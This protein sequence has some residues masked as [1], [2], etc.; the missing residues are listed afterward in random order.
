M[1]QVVFVGSL[2][3]LLGTFSG[4]SGTL[5]PEGQTGAICSPTNACNEGLECDQGL[6]GPAT[7]PGTTDP[8]WQLADVE[9]TEKDAGNE[10]VDPNGSTGLEDGD[11]G[12]GGLDDVATDTTGPTGLGDFGAPCD[13][14]LDCASGLCA[15]HMGDTVCTKTCESEC[16]AGWSCE[17]V[18]L[19]GGDPIYL[20]VSLFE[21]LCQPC[22][23]ASDCE[24]LTSIAACVGYGAEG[25]FCGAACDVDGDCPEAFVCQEAV[26]TRGGGSKQCVH[27]SGV[28]SCSE[29]AISLGLQ[30]E[31]EI[32]NDYGTC[33]AARSCTEDGLTACDALTPAPEACNGIDDDCNGELDEGALCDDGDPCTEDLCEGSGGCQNVIA[34]SAPC[35]DG[36]PA[37]SGDLCN[38]LGECGG[39]AIDCPLGLCELESTPNGDSCDVTFKAD[40]AVC[41]D[42]DVDT[43]GDQCDGSGGCAGS[44]YAC[45]ATQCEATS[46]TNGEG[47]EVEHWALGHPC[48][49]GNTATTGDQCD[50]QGL[51]AGTLYECVPNQCENSSEADGEGCVATYK[52]EGIACDDG[53]LSTNG[54][55]CDGQGGCA[56]NPYT[57][58]VT[59]CDAVSVPNGVAATPIIGPKGWLA[60]TDWTRLRMISVTVRGAAQAHLTPALLASVSSAPPPTVRDATSSMPSRVRRAMTVRMARSV[61]NATVKGAAPGLRMPARLRSARSPLYLTGK[62]VCLLLRRRA[63]SVMTTTPGPKM[64][65]AMRRAAVSARPLGVLPRFV[66]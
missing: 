43:K 61:T 62:V 29:Q 40:G 8:D 50:G 10:W 22:V 13:E 65:P 24:S 54:D 39:V 57:C 59:Q 44:P 42:D 46:V 25:A 32:T 38:E 35:D 63:P 2:A 37:T 5:T 34:P 48:D 20:C 12:A 53:D 45:T 6:C 58:P 51:C 17:Q 9:D 28:C 47:C 19:G 27:T 30:T 21:R 14:D 1:K 60:M 23:E 66:R 49:D 11:D 4:C 55:A 31:C 18:L 41:D 52:L 64:T 36:D 26:S 16:P 56:G 7:L 15:E 3:V 33:S